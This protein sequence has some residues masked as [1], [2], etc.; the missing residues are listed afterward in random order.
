V[1]EHDEDTMRAADYIIDIG[2][3][4]GSHGGRVVA[5]GTAEEIMQV[6]ES[7]TGQYLK[8]AKYIPVPPV[9]RRPGGWLTV[10]GARVNN[11]K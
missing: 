6:P 1:V 8:G 2:P 4:A 10:K 5:S 3:G 11:L 9:R 7:V